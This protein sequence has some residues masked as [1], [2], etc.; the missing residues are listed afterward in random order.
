MSGTTYPNDIVQYTLNYQ[1]IGN[2]I[3][4]GVVLQD[5]LPGEVSYISGTAA[6]SPAL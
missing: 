6:S 3:A 4:T 1:N 5:T 2:A